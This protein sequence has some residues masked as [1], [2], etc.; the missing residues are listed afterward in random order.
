MDADTEEKVI[1]MPLKHEARESAGEWLD[2]ISPADLREDRAA[3]FKQRDRGGGRPGTETAEPAS[4]PE[5]FDP[6]GD[7]Y[8]AFGWAGNTTLPSLV[9][10]FR[11]GSERAIVYA[12]LDS[13]PSDGSVFLP[14]APGCKGSVIRLRIAGQGGVFIV[15]IQGLRLRRV[16]ELILGHKTPWIHELPPGVVPLRQDEPVIWSIAFEKATP[17]G[18]EK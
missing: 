8:K 13:H 2:G 17:D 4:E 15:V 6:A 9:L 5:S 18:S 11:D 14:S 1:A 7:E 10:I 3:A 16:W 12:H